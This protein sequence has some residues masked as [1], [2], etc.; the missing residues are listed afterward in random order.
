MNLSKVNQFIGLEWQY[1]DWDCWQ[2]FIVASEAIFGVT[3]APIKIP[4]QSDPAE[5]AVLMDSEALSWR[6][7]RQVK[8]PEPGCAVFCRDRHGT[9]VHVGLYVEGGNVLHTMGSLDRPG[10]TS[11]DELKLLRR[12][13]G[14]IEFFA[15]VSHH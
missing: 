14:T 2:T 7:W 10:N 5:A 15:Y 13:F 3:V 9:A 12:L 8:D 1:P 4:R 6:K 11:Y